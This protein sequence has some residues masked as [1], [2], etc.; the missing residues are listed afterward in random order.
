MKFKHW[1]DTES[2]IDNFIIISSNALFIASVDSDHI[3]STNAQ[4]ENGTSPI[5]VFGTDG[6]D[7]FPL[8]QMQ[9]IIS[10]NTDR[11][12]DIRYKTKKEI[13]EKTIDFQTIEQKAKFIKVLSKVMPDSLVKK[14]TQQSA[15]VAA[16]SPL[17]SLIIGV[18]VVY[19]FFDKFRWVSTIV[20]GLWAIGSAYRLVTRFS[21]PPEITR[22]SIKGKHLRKTWSVIKTGFSYL[23]LIAIA[24]ALYG[25]FPNSYGP[26][27][28]IQHA[29]QGELIADDIQK[30]MD[31]G[32]DINLKDRDQESALFIAMYSDDE[33]LV[34][35]LIAQGADL[36]GLV[37]DSYKAL[38]YAIADEESTSVFRAMLEKGA[39]TDFT[40]EE[41]PPLKWAQENGNEEL[42]SL[43]VEFASN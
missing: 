6:M 22:W 28:I 17:I 25:G 41:M 15:I 16:I 13:E 11:D 14:V 33:D 2:E 27:S 39:S 40:I 19:F 21:S 30:F 1:V 43:L 18:A 5:E 26:D 12:V 35:E 38:E 8:N 29:S 34:L 10:R 32:A 31:R 37:S 3:E 20:G 23:V 7:I 36:Q 42:A 9:S 24:I 4:L